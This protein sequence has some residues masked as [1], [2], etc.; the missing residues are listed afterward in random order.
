ML[1]VSNPHIL[2][3]VDEFDQKISALLEQYKE[4]NE[5]HSSKLKSI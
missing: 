3:R 2:E 5:N 1:N 4:F